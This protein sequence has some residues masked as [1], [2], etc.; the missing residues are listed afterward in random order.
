MKSTLLTLPSSDALAVIG[1]DSGLT[2][3]DP[4]VGEVKLTVGGSWTVIDTGLEVVVAPKLSV[5]RA[6]SEW[7]PA[8]GFVYD[9]LYGADVSVPIWTPSR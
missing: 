7:L 2:K 1:I 6:V 9:A 5:A 3:T 8:V 4:F